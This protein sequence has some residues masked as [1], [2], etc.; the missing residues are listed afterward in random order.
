MGNSA[1]KIVEQD[2]LQGRARAA[3]S[4]LE[5]LEG[6]MLAHEAGCASDEDAHGRSKLFG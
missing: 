5:E 3:R 1:L 6:E 4:R 2:T